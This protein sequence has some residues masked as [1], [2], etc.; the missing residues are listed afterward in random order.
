MFGGDKRNRLLLMPFIGVGYLYLSFLYLY[1]FDL[2]SG[3]FF[4]L[5]LLMLIV[6]CAIFIGVSINVRPT[7]RSF[8]ISSIFISFLVLYEY[9]LLF[10]DDSES[11][12][13]L[14]YPTHEVVEGSGV[15]IASV[16]TAYVT[17][18]A[19]TEFENGIN[20][21]GVIYID[22]RLRYKDKVDSFYGLFSTRENMDV[23]MG[24]NLSF[25]LEEIPLEISEY[26]TREDRSGDSSGLALTLSSLSKEDSWNNELPIAVTGA[27]DKE[28][29]VLEV[30]LIQEK[31]LIVARDGH[32]HMIVPQANLSEAEKVQQENS[33]SIKISGVKNVEDAIEIIEKWN[34]EAN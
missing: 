5:L 20:Q 24:E 7:C 4:V 1:L 18:G 22:N 6:L 26:L 9:P 13:Y 2:L 34:E 15:F 28:G 31:V 3:A 14:Y 16:L 11:I 10:M 12:H 8:I 23:T 33:F 29:N 32:T 25:L 30:G 27:I 17:E 21:Y 19:D